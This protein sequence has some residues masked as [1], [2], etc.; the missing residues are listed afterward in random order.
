MTWA[1]IELDAPGNAAAI[2]TEALISRG[3]V[4]QVWVLPVDESKVI[5]ADVLHCLP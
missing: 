5:A 2:G 1:G 4:V 3:Q